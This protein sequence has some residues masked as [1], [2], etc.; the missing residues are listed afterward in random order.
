MTL[1]KSQPNVGWRH[2]V[3]RNLRPPPQDTSNRNQSE[4]DDE[5]MFQ[6]VK[7]EIP[8]IFKSNHLQA[9][10]LVCFKLSSS[11]QNVSCSNNF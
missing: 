6:M 4:I 2:R 7:D 11:D 10:V 1:H 3:V 8:T 5:S 9:R